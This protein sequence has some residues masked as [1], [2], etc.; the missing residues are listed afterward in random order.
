[1]ESFSYDYAREKRKEQILNIQQKNGT[2][3][4]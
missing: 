2:K 3:Y 4:K 1:V